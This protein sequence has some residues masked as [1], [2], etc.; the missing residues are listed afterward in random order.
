MFLT[1]NII[2]SL[3]MRFLFVKEIE[4]YI[5]KREER[6]TEKEWDNENKRKDVLV[7]MRGSRGKCAD[8]SV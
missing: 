4:N 3:S 5:N 8:L 2:F 1:S 7:G 6:D